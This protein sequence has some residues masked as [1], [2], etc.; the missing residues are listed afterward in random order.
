[1]T[2]ARFYTLTNFVPPRSH[3]GSGPGKACPA[4]ETEV[5][6]ASLEAAF[7]FLTTLR[8]S[9]PESESSVSDSFFERFLTGFGILD[10][11]LKMKINWQT[12]LSWTIS[13]THVGKIR[14]LNTKIKLVISPLSK[15]RSAKHNLK[16]KFYGLL[17]KQKKGLFQCL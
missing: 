16:I 6:S 8:S 12:L 1:M 10:G 7:D 3:E 4:D 5:V 13:D 2:I 17:L 9:G 15:L 11:R 14:R